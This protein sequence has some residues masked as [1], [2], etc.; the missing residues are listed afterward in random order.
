LNGIVTDPQSKAISAAT[1]KLG[2]RLATTVSDGSYRFESVS[3]GTYK[4][5]FSAPGF[6]DVTR[7]VY[8]A[9]AT[10]LDFQLHRLA[11]HAESVTVTADVTDLNIDHPDPGQRVLVRN[12]IPDAN[13]GRP[14]A[15]VSIPG[16]PLRDR[17][18][19]AE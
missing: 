1:A 13:P 14:G 12:E 19:L 6:D 16:L 17:L 11:R 4:I 8:V 7:E 15:P 2:D 10:R 18:R 9:G 5:T 3:A